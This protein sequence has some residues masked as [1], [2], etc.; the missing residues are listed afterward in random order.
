MSIRLVK[1]IVLS[2]AIALVCAPSVAR[3]DGYVNPWAGVNFGTQFENG[4]GGFGVS[5]GAM[6]HGIVGG[7]ATF[8]FNP[9]F[10]GSSNDFGTNTV[11]DLM[12]NVIIGIPVGGQ[13]GAG[14]RPYV[15]GGLG[16]IRTQID[17]GQV[18][19]PKFSDN[20]FGWNA[21]AGVMGYFNDHIGLRGDLRYFRTINSNF[22][23]SFDFDNG[24]FHYWRTSIGL[25]IR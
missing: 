22:P 20:N 3:A 5:A 16:L 10:F 6:G 17:G 9:S 12:G 23:D 18:F 25:V 2:A 21:G 15:T 14:F 8:G 4:R 13:H 7:E 11:L 1:P 19:V 24:E